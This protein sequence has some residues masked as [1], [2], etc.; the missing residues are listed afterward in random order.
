MQ[1]QEYL[2]SAAQNIQV[3]LRYASYLKR[4]PSIMMEQ[5]K[6][7]IT[8]DVRSFLDLKELVKS[9]IGQS[10]LFGFTSPQLSF[11]ETQ[12]ARYF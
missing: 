11:I 4:S 5:I 7:A 9:K 12:S 6:G 1:I 2:V 10:V 8:G 3:L